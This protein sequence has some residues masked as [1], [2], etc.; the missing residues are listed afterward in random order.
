MQGR[1]GVDEI[2][3]EDGVVLQLS[4]GEVV[5]DVLVVGAEDFAL[6]LL[7]K[8]VPDIAALLIGKQDPRRLDGRR[9]HE[10]P[11][12]VQVELVGPVA[13]HPVGN[14]IRVGLDIQA[15]RVVGVGFDDEVEALAEVPHEVLLLYARERLDYIDLS[16]SIGEALE[17]SGVYRGGGDLAAPYLHL[18]GGICGQ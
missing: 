18:Y 1:N 7:Y 8:L 6:R 16:R 15:L 5:V 12:L 11:L 4:R 2:G 9:R 3:G 17:G 14:P 10:A 13:I